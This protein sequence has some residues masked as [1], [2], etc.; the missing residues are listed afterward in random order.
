MAV[1]PQGAIRLC[2]VSRQLGELATFSLA[3][4]RLDD[5]WNSDYLRGVRRKLAAGECI[6]ECGHCYATEKTGGLSRRLI[7]NARWAKDLGPLLD[8]LLATSL[9]EDGNV[10]G[11]PIYYQLMPGNLCNLKCRMCF[12]SYSS[13]IEK[14]AV[15]SAWTPSFL[16][17]PM[18]WSGTSLSLAPKVPQRAHADGFHGLET[19]SAGVPFRWTKGAASVAIRP[20]PGIRLESVRVRLARRRRWGQKVRIW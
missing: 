6:A 2:C 19:S 3:S 13:Q 15:H 12:P 20:P 8:R 17:E 4:D 9:A 18:T 11:A 14:D 7:S 10:P 1:Y 5:V 16:P